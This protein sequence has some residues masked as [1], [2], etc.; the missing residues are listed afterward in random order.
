MGFEPGQT[1]RFVSAN[2]DKGTLLVTDGTYDVEVRPE[3]LTNDLDVANIARRRDQA[4]QQ[5][6]HTIIATAQSE[7]AKIRM[8]ANVDAAKN[9]GRRPSGAQIGSSSSLNNGTTRVGLWQRYPYGSP[10]YYLNR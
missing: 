9:I 2:A 8:A 10:Y 6:L 7:D 4:S 3:Q 1:V 5:Q